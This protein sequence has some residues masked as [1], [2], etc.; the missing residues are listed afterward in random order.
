MGHEKGD[1]SSRNMYKGP[2]D[3]AKRGRFN[4]GRWGWVGWGTMVRG[5]WTQL[6]LNNNL[7]NYK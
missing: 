1:G 6:Y 5:K 3:K 2:M 7:K 4:G